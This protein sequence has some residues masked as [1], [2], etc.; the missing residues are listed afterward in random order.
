VCHCAD[1]SQHDLSGRVSQGVAIT[2]ALMLKA[3]PLL[4][5]TPRCFHAI[6]FPDGASSLNVP[7][8]LDRIQG[9]GTRSETQANIAVRQP[10]WAGPGKLEQ[11]KAQ[12]INGKTAPL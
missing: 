4:Q 6:S 1:H 12:I 7:P 3:R 5:S 11:S 9:Q 2:L 10:P 8:L